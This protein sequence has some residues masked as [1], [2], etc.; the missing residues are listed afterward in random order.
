MKELEFRP[1]KIGFMAWICKVKMPGKPNEYYEVRSLTKRG[2]IRKA[3]NAHIDLLA[4]YTYQSGL[5]KRGK[6]I[7]KEI[8]ELP[9]D[10]PRTVDTD[11][12]R[13][14][15]QDASESLEPIFTPVKSEYTSTI[16]TIDTL[17]PE[18]PAEKAYDLTTGRVIPVKDEE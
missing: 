5:P 6:T 14:A 10:S 9:P 16:G 13:L 4:S 1:T 7:T 2:S 17:R 12:P 15:G 8:P 18:K 3:K 11:F